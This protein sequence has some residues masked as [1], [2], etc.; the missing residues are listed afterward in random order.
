M[1]TGINAIEF[2][3]RFNCN[4]ACY[5]YLIEW[6]WGKGF[7]CSRCAVRQIIKGKLITIEDAGVV[8][9]MRV[10]QLALFFMV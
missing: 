3:K 6:K 10:L 2:N 4:E 8:V 7:S 9:M 5:K 1:F